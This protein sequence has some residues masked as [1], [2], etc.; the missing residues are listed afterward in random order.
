MITINNLLIPHIIGAIKFNTFQDSIIVG[1]F[2][3]GV[4][5][6]MLLSYF[7]ASNSINEVFSHSRDQDEDKNPYVRPIIITVILGMI[8][9][10][11][12]TFIPQSIY[13]NVEHKETDIL[14]N[15]YVLVKIDQRSDA[16]YK[17]LGLVDATSFEKHRYRII[18]N[19]NKEEEINLRDG[20]QVDNFEIEIDVIYTNDNSDTPTVEIHDIIDSHQLGPYKFK[21]NKVKEVH[22]LY[23]PKKYK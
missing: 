16:H 22:K 17:S 10:L 5:L 21:D 9:V 8:L 20:L 23:I 6:V 18:T 1:V 2:I 13:N 15:E 4:I 7:I 11:I 14:K 19:D 12:A 3:T